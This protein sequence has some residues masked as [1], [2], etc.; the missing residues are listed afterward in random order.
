M[1]VL[2]YLQLLDLVNL[3]LPVHVLQVRESCGPSFGVK[4][5]IYRKVTRYTVITKCRCTGTLIVICSY[6]EF[7]TLCL[8]FLHS[9]ALFTTSPLGGLHIVCCLPSAQDNGWASGAFARLSPASDANRLRYP[10]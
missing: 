8:L 1:L 4:E 6:D 10:S 5:R 3:L 7:V 9:C 2:F